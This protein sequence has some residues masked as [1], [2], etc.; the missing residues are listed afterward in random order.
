VVK[1]EIKAEQ[2]QQP[3]GLAAVEFLS[4]LEVLEV[5]VIGPDLNQMLHTF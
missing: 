1:R 3:A 2:V 5:F 4:R